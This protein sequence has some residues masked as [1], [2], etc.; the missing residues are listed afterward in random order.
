MICGKGRDEDEEKNSVF[1]FAMRMRLVGLESRAS[2]FRFGNSF[3]KFERNSLL[4]F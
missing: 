1:Y 4:T 2:R 3:F